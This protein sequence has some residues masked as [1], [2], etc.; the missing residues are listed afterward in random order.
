MEISFSIAYFIITL[1]LYNI[2]FRK[3]GYRGIDTASVSSFPLYVDGRSYGKLLRE[4]E[5]E[6][7]DRKEHIEEGPVGTSLE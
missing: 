6:S 2:G 1:R 5:R 4:R 3:R 7:R